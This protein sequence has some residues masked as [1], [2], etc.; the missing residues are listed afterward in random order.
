MMRLAPLSSRPHSAA[1]CRIPAGCGLGGWKER[2]II[3]EKVCVG[4]KVW[5][6]WVTG[7]LEFLVEVEREGELV[8]RFNDGLF[9]FFFCCVCDRWFFERGIF[10]LSFVFLLLE[11]SPLW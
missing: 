10:G 8:G 7:R 1:M 11:K 9:F 2:V 3:G 5:R 6:R 4:R